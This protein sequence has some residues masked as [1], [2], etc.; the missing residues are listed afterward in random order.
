MV[1]SSSMFAPSLTRWIGAVAA[2]WLLLPRIVGLSMELSRRIRSGTRAAWEEVVTSRLLRA[3]VLLVATVIVVACAAACGAAASGAALSHHGESAFTNSLSG[4]GASEDRRDAQEAR[5][6]T[7]QKVSRADDFRGRCPRAMV[8]I[9]GK[10]C[11]DRYEA[12]LVDV[13]PGGEERPHSPFT[14]VGERHLV[15]AVSAPDVFPQGYISAV[16][17][18]RACSAA[19]KRLC[20][21]AEWSKACRGPATQSFGYGERREPGRCNDKGKNPVISLYGRG[22][23]TWSTMNQPA[24]NQQEGTLSRTGEHEGCTNGYGV[25]DMVG[26]LHEWVADPRGTFYGGYYQDVASVGHGA[27]CGYQT[28]AHEARYHDYST[29]FRCCGDVAG[30]QEPA[31]PSKATKAR[32]RRKATRRR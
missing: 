18:Q 32:G 8:E 28:T 21:V 7:T 25:F 30:A 14:P 22:H 24:L 15:R 5:V 4:R 12:T 3:I 9:D 6:A 17:A 1:F 10:F 11:I 16:E 2:R 31:A 26:N 23:W 27:G 19:G 13:L 29:G 20:G